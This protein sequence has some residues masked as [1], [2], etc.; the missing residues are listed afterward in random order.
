MGDRAREFE[1]G[2][3]LKE[4]RLRQNLDFPQIETTT[5]IRGK[6]LQALEDE[7]FH[8]LPEETYI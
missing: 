5:N 2:S 3:S 8:L 6:Y 7:Q 4:A 1:I